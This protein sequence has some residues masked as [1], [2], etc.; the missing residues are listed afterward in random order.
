MWDFNL[1]YFNKSLSLSNRKVGVG[2]NLVKVYLLLTDTESILSQ[3]IKQ[4]TKQKYNHCSLAFDPE[5]Q[6]TYSFGRKQPWNP[7]NGGFVQEDLSADFFLSAD[8]AIYSLS[9][10]VEQRELMLAFIHEL[11]LQKEDMKYNLLGLF[12]AFFEIEWE[13]EHHYFCS[14]FVATTLATAG[15]LQ[16]I[17]PL[18]FITPYDLIENLPLEFVF[19]GTIYQY[20]QVTKGMWPTSILSRNQLLL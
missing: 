1:Y 3:T 5:L 4:F 9:V 15:V 11:D 16:P 17:K 6:Q 14:E 2:M 19:E 10:T 8:C 20:T 18:S 7:F 13:R 12:T